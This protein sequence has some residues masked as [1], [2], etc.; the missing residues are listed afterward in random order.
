MQ[1]QHQHQHHQPSAAV[2][3]TESQIHM[4][5]VIFHVIFG[6]DVAGTLELVQASAVRVH[7]IT[8]CPFLAGM[9]QRMTVESTDE[10]KALFFLLLNVDMVL[11]EYICKPGCVKTF[12][13]A[14]NIKKSTENSM[15][16]QKLEKMHAWSMMGMR[17]L[18]P[19]K[20]TRFFTVL[21]YSLVKTWLQDER[22]VARDLLQMVKT[23][24]LV[25]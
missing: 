5:D 21:H 24:Y 9:M 2:I 3:H 18:D 6:S 20:G 11:K 17:G 19:A 13:S 7:S 12:S 15:H 14:M 25:S 10:V 4:H 23:E 22:L 1:Q 8:H 16:Q